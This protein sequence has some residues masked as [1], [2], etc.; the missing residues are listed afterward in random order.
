MNNPDGHLEREVQVF[1]KG[2]GH[3]AEIPH[4]FRGGPGPLSPDFAH[5][6]LPGRAP[7]SDLPNQRKSGRSDLQIGIV[8]V[9]DLPA[10]VGLAGGKPDF[11]HDDVGEGHG[12]VACQEEGS[13]RG[14]RLHGGE[15]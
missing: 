10:H 12:V 2:I 14:I 1:C 8:G 15:G 11:T 13:G 3:R 5:R 6:L 9:F 4:R 7:D